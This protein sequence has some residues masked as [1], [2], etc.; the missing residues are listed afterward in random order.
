MPYKKVKVRGGW[1]I[2]GPSGFKSKEPLTEERA[3]AQLR[4]LYANA[5]PTQESLK[6]KDKT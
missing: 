2:K 1:K 5:S 4:A 6:R 3:D